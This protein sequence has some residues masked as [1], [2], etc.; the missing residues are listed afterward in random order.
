MKILFVIMSIIS[1]GLIAFGVLRKKKKEATGMPSIRRWD[2][3]WIPITLILGE[4]DFLPDEVPRLMSAIKAG[5]KFW[6]TQTGLKLFAPQGDIG[7]GGVIPVKRRDP[8]TMESEDNAVAIASLTINQKGE[9][10]NAVVYMNNWEN[11]PS[12]TLDRAMKHEL[13]HC[14]GLD[15][16]ESDLSVMYGAVSRSVYCV[17]P[18]D[19][20]FLEEVY[21]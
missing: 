15:H 20:A 11:L 21:G 17:S 12:L 4:E 7:T 19:K 16:D 9:L 13:G 2:K 6:N 3:K 1:V 5:A 8:L 14:L 18:A 10:K